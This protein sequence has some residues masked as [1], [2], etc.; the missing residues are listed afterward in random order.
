MHT[1]STIEPATARK[2]PPSSAGHY[3]DC[4]LPLASERAERRGAAV[5]ICTRCGLP[6]AVRWRRT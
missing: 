1:E 5:R 2:P 3:C 4:A 6:I